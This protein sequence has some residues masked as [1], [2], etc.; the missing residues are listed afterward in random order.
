[1]ID[2][3]QIFTD[4]LTLRAPRAS[5]FEALREFGRSSE[6]MRFLGGVAE[7]NVLWRAFLADL[8]HWALRSYGFF[9]IE[10]SSTGQFVGRAGPIFH[11]HNAEPELAWHLFEGFDG[12]GYATEAA[13]AARDWYYAHTGNGRL[14]SWVNVENHA[15]QGVAQRLGAVLEG[16][17]TTA[18]GH[19][20]QI[21]RHL[22]RIA[23]RTS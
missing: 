8:G 15:S 18:S 4:R 6:R 13:A 7:E 14:M 5:D 21:W 10:L 19:E 2:G 16:V 11:L 9:S 1:M 20:G 17:H 23:S 3:P 22:P 12:M